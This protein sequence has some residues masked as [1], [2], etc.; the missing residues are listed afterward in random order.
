MWRG[1]IFGDFWG[2]F[3]RARV[4]GEVSILATN[5]GS[6]CAFPAIFGS[7]EHVARSHFFRFLQV[8]CDSENKKPPHAQATTTNGTRK[9]ETIICEPSV[10]GCE[11]RLLSSFGRA[12]RARGCGDCIFCRDL[13]DFATKAPHTHL[14]YVR[15][16]RDSGDFRRPRA[17]GEVT[18][19]AIFA[20]FKRL[21]E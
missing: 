6:K 12:G 20:S 11:L 3:D 16:V 5:I 15:Q 10:L 1:L 2:S 8:V 21:Q 19:F 18:F 9:L 13:V 4:C 14:R 7:R 17:C